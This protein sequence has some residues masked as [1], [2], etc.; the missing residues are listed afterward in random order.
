LLCAHSPYSTQMSGAGA[1]RLSSV[2]SEHAP[3][4]PGVGRG[5]RASG[6]RF[7]GEVMLTALALNT[8]QVI[9]LLLTPRTYRTLRK[10]T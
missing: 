9:I 1:T 5:G 4:A 6:V 3:A 8:S 10:M 2:D 7:F